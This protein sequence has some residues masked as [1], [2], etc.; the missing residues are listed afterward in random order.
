MS[1]SKY[2][3]REDCAHRVLGVLKHFEGL[4]DMPVFVAIDV[5]QGDAI[6][7][8]KEERTLLV[9]G[10]NSART[11]PKRFVKCT[12]RKHVDV[13]VC[14][15]SEA[16]HA[17]GV[18]GF[19]KGSCTADQVWLP[20]SW[21]KRLADLISDPIGFFKESV[22]DIGQ[23]EENVVT[24][25]ETLS[26]MFSE[27]QYEK[28][29]AIFEADV[30]SFGAEHT[31]H[32]QSHALN[33]FLRSSIIPERR[34]KRS[35]LMIEAVIAAD[36]IKEITL[37]AYRSGSCIRWFEYIGGRQQTKP[38]GGIK[39]FL[40]PVNCT[41]LSRIRYRSSM[42]ALEYIAL[43]RANRESLT[44]V[45]PRDSISP[46]VLFTSDSD[47]SFRQTIPWSKE[48]I[49]TAPHH[50]S[51]NNRRAYQRFRSETMNSFNVTWV[52]SD[53]PTRSKGGR[54]GKS[55]TSMNSRYCTVCRGPI[56]SYQIVKLSASS[57]SSWR[58]VKTRKCRC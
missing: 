52:R 43:T 23:L 13:L 10:G 1:I 14:T 25:L 16:D 31:H 20:A 47:L 19:L 7:M 24:D 6:F 9:D 29:D 18:L 57:N 44:F 35:R 32:Y 38:T 2:A 28:D 4:L 17:R 15:H 49:V 33:E 3:Y 50:G 11:F 45:S 40:V 54:P 5:R 53:R 34:D 37:A 26:E 58:P 21:T 51:E 42:S 46:G 22:K 41:E 39:H 8:E 55:Y 36:V 56:W 27:R 30:N 48:M 12:G